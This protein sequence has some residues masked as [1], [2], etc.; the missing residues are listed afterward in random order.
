MIKRSL[1]KVLTT[2]LTLILVLVSPISFANIAT[3]TSLDDEKAVKKQL[4]KIQ[5]DIQSLEKNLHHA[6]AQ[7]ETHLSQLAALE[8]DLGEKEEKRR[9]ILNAI[10]ANAQKVTQLQK[11]YQTELAHCDKE[12]EALATLLKATYTGQRHEKFKILLNPD[13]TAPLARRNQYYQYFY[14]ARKQRLQELQTSLTELNQLQQNL[15]KEQAHQ[16]Q[17][18]DSLKAE[19]LA[20]EK[21]RDERKALLDEMHQKTAEEEASLASLKAQ[22]QQ[23]DKVFKTLQ[24]KLAS[25]DLKTPSSLSFAKMKQKLPWPLPQDE[26]KDVLTQKKPNRNK[27]NLYFMA[28]EGTPVTA[29]FSG[30]VVFSEWLRGIGLLIII[31]HGQGYMSLYG[32]NQKLY[33]SIGDTVEQGEMI[34]RVGQSGGHSEGGLYFEIRKDG[35]PLDPLLWFQP[36]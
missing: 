21:T 34:A 15:E 19:R 23:L 14:A 30:N 25:A 26:L 7:E 13:E 5:S 2:R 16:L 22:A 20:F 24:T 31:D 33:K 12:R 11:A 10:A 3:E 18:A 27:Q 9:S 1:L 28:E 4:A 35:S 8:K 6:K 32:N 17:L 36:I 29:I